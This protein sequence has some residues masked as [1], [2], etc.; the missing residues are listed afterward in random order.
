MPLLKRAGEGAFRLTDDC[1]AGAE[2]GTVSVNAGDHIHSGRRSEAHDLGR[3]G[4]KAADVLGAQT[5]QQ[6]VGG[7][8]NISERFTRDCGDCPRARR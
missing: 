2:G 7:E 4:L 8:G 6:F 3:S 1:L 5:G